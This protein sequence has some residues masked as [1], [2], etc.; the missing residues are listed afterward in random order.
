MGLVEGKHFTVK[1][2][3]GDHDGYVYVR[4]KGLK[5]A[6]WLSVYGSGRQRV[7]AAKFV[8]YILQ[9]AERTSKKV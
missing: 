2:P 7:L 9:R 1:M 4:R 8:E 5:H 3:E 6:A